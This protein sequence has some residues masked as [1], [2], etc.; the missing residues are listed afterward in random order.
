MAI[1]TVVINIKKLDG[2]PDESLSEIL[3]ELADSMM[4]GDRMRESEIHYGGA[5]VG[6]THWIYA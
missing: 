2:D 5:L 3:R 4:K 1:Y 6:E